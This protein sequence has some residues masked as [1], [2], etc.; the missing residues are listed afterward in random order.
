[1]ITPIFGD[2][3][4]IGVVLEGKDEET[5]QLLTSTLLSSIS[6][7][8]TYASWPRYFEREKGAREA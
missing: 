7:K 8:S 3:N 1:M 2:R 5:L 6:V 4:V